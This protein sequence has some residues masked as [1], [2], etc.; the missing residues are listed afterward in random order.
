M[1]K[2]DNFMVYWGKNSTYNAFL[3]AAVGVGLGL[4]AFP[5]LSGSGYASVA[6][7]VLV[8]LGVLGHL[9]AVAR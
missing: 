3:H 8:L 4:L 5:Y 2:K 9:Y 7:W 6:G 1:A